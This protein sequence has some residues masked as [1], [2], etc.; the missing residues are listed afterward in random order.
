MSLATLPR[1]IPVPT[2]LRRA[3]SIPDEVRNWTPRSLL[4]QSIRKA[5]PYLPRDLVLEL[6]ERIASAGV[7]ESSLSLRVIRGLGLWRAG[8]IPGDE[9][10]I[11]DYGVV[12]RKVVTTAGVG[13]I[14]DAWQNLVELETMKY[15][16]LGTGVV[17]EAVGDTALGTELTTQYTGDV[18]ATG[19][20]TENAANIFETVGT[21]TLD[22][23]TPAVTEHGI[24]T[25]AAT[26]GGTLIDRSVFS[27]INLNGAN[28]DGLQS[29]YRHTQT[30]GG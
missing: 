25:Q 3:T 23:G 10:V 26:G 14:V 18:R 19:S 2:V 7:I 12:S 9:V 1:M 21:N 6:V 28:G 29:T 24:L 13:F 22:S 5:L 11:E 8:L 20:L 27:A 17:A 16:A 30:A 4:G 15:H